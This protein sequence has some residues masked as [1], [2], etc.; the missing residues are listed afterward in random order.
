METLKKKPDFSGY[1]T[2]ADVR[3]NDGAVIDPDAFK[4]MSGKRVPLVWNH[5]RNNPNNI[6]GSVE[7]EHRGNGVYA[8]AFFNDST[9]AQNAKS[10]VMH[11]DMTSMSIFANN[12]VRQG[13]RILDGDI[14][15]V[16]LVYAG[17]NPGAY[18]D[19]ISHSE[20]NYDD[21]EVII[22][23]DSYIE[24]EDADE[25][26]NADETET[27]DKDE[28][29]LK[30]VYETLNDEQ[31]E[32]LAVVVNGIAKKSDEEKKSEEDETKESEEDSV[33]HGDDMK[34]RNV[35][36][37]SGDD[38]KDT[39][40]HANKT[41]IYQA[42][43]RDAI[44]QNGKLKNFA[45][46]HAKE[47]GIQNMELLFPEA[48]SV[49][50][51]PEFLMRKQ[52]WVNLLLNGVRHTPFSR[53]KTMFADITADEARAKGYIT[54][55]K[56]EDEFFKLQKRETY[57]QTIYKKQRFDRDD[58]LDAAGFDVIGYVKQE[59]ILMLREEIARA[60]LIGDGRTNDSNDKI[61]EENIRPIIADDELFTITVDLTEEEA[62]PEKLIRA[63]REN[64]DDFLGSGAPTFF[65]SPSIVTGLSLVEDKIGRLL[66]PTMNEL[67]SSLMVGNVA[68]TEVLKGS[69]IEDKE[70]V[71]VIVN[72]SDYNIGRDRGGQVNFFEDFDLDFNQNKY[73][74]ET[75]LSGA[76]VRP[77]SAMVLT[78][79][80]TT[81]GTGE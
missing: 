76:L 2:R 11:K 74:Y 1:A 38:S 19:T 45:I 23:T 15:E 25:E 7:L 27:S 35:F 10:A 58:I 24:H 6:L 43:V 26:K 16:S 81:S 36:E 77:K 31:K 80:A 73:L 28:K 14:R 46:E 78:K 12:V 75:R 59:M 17:N 30:E 64:L 47:Y 69:K 50:D 29:T 63:V 53:V 42:S 49:F 55:K 56:K 66:Y 48:K 62:K 8:Q 37:A 68:R 20:S 41:E 70:I 9:E 32:L 52:D 51:K 44:N 13:P 4:H 34:H 60:I 72:P 61:N 67:S 65:A 21:E 54:G 57:P 39:I 22:Y 18:I 40:S 33:K 79:P 5:Q 3:C 71:A